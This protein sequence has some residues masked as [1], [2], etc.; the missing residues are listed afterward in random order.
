MPKDDA[1]G[2]AGLWTHLDN[3]AQSKNSEE[4]V[5]AVT[6]VTNVSVKL[7]PRSAS[8]LTRL[9]RQIGHYQLDSRLR[10]I[11]DIRYAHGSVCQGAVYYDECA[12]SGSHGAWQ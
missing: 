1:L 9:V 5:V 10:C 2:V 6:G 4:L 8:Y 7:R 12:R 11:L 3:L